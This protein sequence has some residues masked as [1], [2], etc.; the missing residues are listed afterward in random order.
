MGIEDLLDLT[1]VD[2]EAAADDQLLLPVDDEEETVL[3]LVAHVA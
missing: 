2:V 3:I 1:R